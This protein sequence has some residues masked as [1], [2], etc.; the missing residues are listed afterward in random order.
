MN[1]IHRTQFDHERLNLLP[2]VIWSLVFWPSVTRNW[3]KA[4]HWNKSGWTFDCCHPYPLTFSYYQF[5]SIYIS[6][7][8]TGFPKA[9]WEAR[10]WRRVRSARAGDQWEVRE[11][12]HGNDREARPGSD[13]KAREKGHFPPSHH[14]HLRLLLITLFY[15]GREGIYVLWMKFVF[16]EP[17]RIRKAA[18]I[19]FVLDNKY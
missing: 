10:C 7:Y 13:G 11:R 1:G 2:L 4:Q 5:E 16:P 9:Y 6:A 18:L 14:H 19:S 15:L 3:R 12:D 17:I 8:S